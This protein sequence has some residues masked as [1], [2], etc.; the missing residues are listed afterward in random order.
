ME[1][2]FKLIYKN[3]EEYE[4]DLKSL[5]DDLK[6]IDSLK[7]KLKELESF[8]LF[9][10]TSNR[11]DAK[12][13]NLYL[14][15]SLNHD[16]NQKDPVSA[17]RYQVMFSKYME[18]IQRLSFVEP[19]ILK[20]DKNLLLK[21]C[22]EIDELKPSYFAIEKIFRNNKYVKSAKI[23]EIM[24]RYNDVTSGYQ[25]L[26]DK[27]C[28]ADASAFDVEL[29]DG[30][31]VNV[32]HAN[33]TNLLLTTKKQEDRKKIFESFYNYYESHKNTLASIYSGIIAS[34]FA[35]TKNRGYK[36]ILDS[37]LYR[38]DINKN[39]VYNLISV[40]KNNTKPL[41]RYYALKKKY[42]K[43][44]E[45]HTYDR[46]LKF[47]ESSQKYD[48]ES[49]KRLV[50][51]ALSVFGNDFLNK[52]NQ[53][54]ENGRVSVYPRDGKTIGA[55]ST[56][57]YDK[58]T[59]IMLN[60]T[61]DLNSAFTLA[62]EC[63]HSIHTLYSNEAQP[64]ETH[65]YQIFVAEVASTFNE[66]R[67]LD[68]LLEKTNDKDERIALLQEGIDGLIAT[69]YRQTL[70][71]DFEIEAHKI[72]ENGGVIT[73]EALSSIMKKLY[74]KYYGI[75]LDTEPLKR[76]VWAYIPH[77]FHSPYYVYQYATS[78]SASLA[79]YEDVKNKKPN[80]LNNYIS[81]LK[82]GGSDYPINIIKKA[83][84]DLTTKEPF[85]A[86]VKRLDELVDLLEE[87]LGK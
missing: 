27:L 29:S 39:V 6:I 12:I 8:K 23:E 40:A 82:A 38:N 73:E 28:V 18:V 4:K 9:N 58:G 63:G 87:A 81:M 3:E 54:L 45:L 20:I 11:I 61:D 50:L 2:D 7:G 68:Y 78:Y 83:G 48:Y 10:K 37:K 76:L 59:F 53:A 43:L 55:Y 30:S 80:A 14:Y 77:L 46:F 35:E 64:F 44:K 51:D 67:F 72:Y 34:E 65:E 31:I 57:S 56:G 25:Q 41:R 71:A 49:S 26:Y 32:N 47:K 15:A 84:C 74:K 24:N 21:W 42:F 22:T 75:D 62:H 52:A 85:L 79:I 86:V 17:K 16:L 13:Y 60:H 69:F 19:E 36:S 33:Y 5:D 66:A 70:F 1:W